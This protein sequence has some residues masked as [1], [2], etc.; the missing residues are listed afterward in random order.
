MKY[1]WKIGEGPEMH[2]KLHLGF[3]SSKVFLHHSLS[4]L[5]INW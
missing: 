2:L 3:E 5:V 4:T 1:G